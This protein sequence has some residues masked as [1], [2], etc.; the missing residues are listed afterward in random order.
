MSSK[1]SGVSIVQRPKAPKPQSLSDRLFSFFGGASSAAKES[2]ETSIISG[3][4]ANGSPQMVLTEKQVKKLLGLSRRNKLLKQKLS[5]QTEKYTNHII[6]LVDRDRK[7]K[8]LLKR[9]DETHAAEVQA[10]REQ[11]GRLAK[12]IAQQ[13]D[14]FK[15]KTMKLVKQNQSIAK[16]L[17]AAM[18]RL[19]DMKTLEQEVKSYRQANHKLMETVGKLKR[20]MSEQAS[21]ITALKDATRAAGVRIMELEGTSKDG[22]HIHSNQPSAEIE[23]KTEVEDIMGGLLDASTEA[24]MASV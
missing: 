2:A 4:D 7:Y 20:E 17:S 19:Q 24:N 11:N 6:Q 10:L 18:G 16:E 5:T 1:L 23:A 15:K 9:R 12:G 8:I 21:M 13:H 3:T 14:E 22:V